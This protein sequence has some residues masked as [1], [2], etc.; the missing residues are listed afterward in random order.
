MNSISPTSRNLARHLLATE[1]ARGK[2]SSTG[3]GAAFLPPAARVC[4]KLRT[5]LTVF[6]GIAGFRSLLTRA[7][8]LAA[9]SA[10]ELKGVAVMPDGSLSGIGEVRT[11]QGKRAAL[12]WEQILV[13]QL[14]ELLVAFIGEVLMLQLVS[15]AWPGL[16]ASQLRLRPENKS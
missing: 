7:L 13:A 11:G 4:D 14:L 6:A 15:Q 1:L 5:V 8:T 9:A 2:N 16:P 3:P 10:P 12:D